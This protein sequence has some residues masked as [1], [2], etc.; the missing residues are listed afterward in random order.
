MEDATIGRCQEAGHD[1]K[2]SGF[3][4][5][6]FADEA[7]E[8]PVWNIEVDVLEHRQRICGLTHCEVM[9]QGFDA[10]LCRRL[11]RSIV[12]HDSRLTSLHAVNARPVRIAA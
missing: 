3:A 9:G 11:D 10:E 8:P 1:A 4:A 6:G 5:A 2:Q 12:H 7:D